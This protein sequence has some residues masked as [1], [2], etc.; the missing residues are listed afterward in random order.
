MF[1]LINT[2][3]RFFII[4]LA[5]GVL[6]APR[7]GL[8]TRNM[9]RRHVESFVNEV[10]KIAGMPPI[11]TGAAAGGGERRRGRGRQAEDPS[12]TSSAT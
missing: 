2:A 3:I 9:I 8:D 11:Q 6:I 5:T 7:P 4:G 10:L 1:G 12:A